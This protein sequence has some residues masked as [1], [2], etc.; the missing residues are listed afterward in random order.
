[1]QLEEVFGTAEQ[2]WLGHWQG[3]PSRRAWAEVPLQ[4][5]DQAPDFELPDS[6]GRLRSLSDFWRQRPALVIF[7]RHFGCGCGVERAARLEADHA[8]FVEAGAEVVVIGQGE[9]ARAD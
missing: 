7:W 9:P 5:G 1:M 6:M 8:A 4:V 2:R 3:G